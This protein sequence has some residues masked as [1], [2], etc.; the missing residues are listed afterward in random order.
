MDSSNNVNKS[1]KFWTF[2]WLFIPFFVTFYFMKSSGKPSQPCIGIFKTHS[3]KNKKEE[4]SLNIYKKEKMRMLFEE[5]FFEQT[6][7]A[8]KLFSQSLFFL[9]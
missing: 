6:D 3:K 4:N 9:E 1:S 5:L 7:M 8:T 2:F